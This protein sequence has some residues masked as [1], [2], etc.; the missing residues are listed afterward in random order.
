MTLPKLKPWH[1]ALIALGLV[2]AAGVLL[3]SK[4]ELL[5]SFLSG[6]VA[7]NVRSEYAIRKS[8]VRLVSAPQIPVGTNSASPT[9][10]PSSAELQTLAAS[11]GSL[12]IPS[13]TPTPTTPDD[14][15]LDLTKPSEKLAPGDTQTGPGQH[16]EL[17]EVPG[18]PRSS[19]NFVAP[20]KGNN[21]AALVVG[22][23]D[24]PSPPVPDSL[25]NQGYPGTSGNTANAPVPN[26]A[27]VIDPR[28]Y[29][30]NNLS[31]DAVS[32]NSVV[33]ATDNDKDYSIAGF[34][35]KS[36]II[37][38]AM[39]QAVSSA[40]MELDVKAAVC[41]P[42]VFQ[43]HQLLEIGDQL[44]GTAASSNKRD[45]ILVTWHTILYKNG[46]STAIDAVAQDPSGQIGIPG[47]QIGSRILQ[48]ITPVLL[49]TAAAFV[50]AFRQ[51]AYTT[52]IPNNVSVGTVTVTNNQ[53]AEAQLTDAGLSSVQG[54][55]DKI[56]ELIA[57]DVESNKP[58]IFVMPGV[59]CQAYLR[60]PLDVTKRD[61]G[62]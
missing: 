30:F 24:L 16:K 20:A 5:G 26:A 15:T 61:Y 2:L 13:A 3:A 33:L 10:S 58:Y 60:A 56:S 28:R 6:D 11:K 48:S 25:L 29:L 53:T 46:M 37:K 1:W 18:R 31:P 4:T 49:D 27:T 57:E 44:L 21:D 39:L 8:G 59:R 52:I 7:K 34:A 38:L 51:N 17:S 19:A 47:V 42:F 36:S 14:E 50:Q 40:D 22:S 32:G 54:G 12:T 9:P 62:D 41:E 43:G 23:S 55:L 45:R 35:P